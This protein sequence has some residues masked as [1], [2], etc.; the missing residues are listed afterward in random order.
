MDTRHTL[1]TEK[2]YDEIRN[3]LFSAIKLKKCKKC[4]CMVYGLGDVIENLKII[5][6]ETSDGLARKLSDEVEKLKLELKPVE[7][8][9]LGCKHCH[10]A[11]A[12]NFIADAV[13]YLIQNDSLNDSGNHNSLEFLDS[14]PVSPGEYSAFCD[15]EG[16]PVAVSTLASLDLYS[17]LSKLKPKGLCIIGKT[18][19]EN[20]GIDKIIKNTITNSTLHYLIVSGRESEGHYSGQTLISLYKNGVDKNMRII[21]SNGK[22]PILKNVTCEEVELFRKQV[23]VIN[24]IGCEDTAV[25]TLKISELLKDFKNS[26]PPKITDRIFSP[27]PI[28][29]I[30]AKK[31]KRIK[32]DKK[33][34]FVI[35][36]SFANKTITVEFYNYHNELLNVI[37][38]GDVPSIYSTIIEK[39]LI[40][41]LTHAAYI[42]KELEKAKWCM[43]YN[44]KYIQ[45]EA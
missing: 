45:G 25:I 35:I 30:I 18:E 17:E 21:G 44:I 12:A 1:E 19:T 23:K 5:E 41:E 43:D 39:E 36:P 42:G 38:G 2:L 27:S 15:G 6:N 4:G 40:S 22:K 11:V 7:Y 9:C 26:E 24:M 13:I 10:P 16:C 32:L 31:P 34:Y 37:E 14:W 28:E 20:I 8:S 3:E 29:K 33:G